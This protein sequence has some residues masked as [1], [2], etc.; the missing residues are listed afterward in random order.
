LRDLFETE[1]WVR[2]GAGIP[3]ALGFDMFG[4][5]LIVDLG[6]MPHSLIGGHAGTGESV[7]LDAIIM[8]LLYRSSPQELRIMMIDTTGVVLQPYTLLPHLMAPVV[9][10]PKAAV[11][12][13]RWV[14]SEMEKRCQMFS[15]IGILN[16]RSFNERFS[17][18]SLSMRDREAGRV[19]AV[20]GEAAIDDSAVPVEDA[21]GNKEN[22]IPQSLSHVV[23]INSLSPSEY[24]RR[25]ASAT[26][27]HTT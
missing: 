9:V 23:V 26:A 18:G 14:V 8:S 13:L 17:E 5:P 11:F 15:R 1:Q 6:R 12:A 27:R 21:A 4:D 20:T 10:E 25:H 2:F 16:I 24:V 19:K 7:C 22:L 3:I